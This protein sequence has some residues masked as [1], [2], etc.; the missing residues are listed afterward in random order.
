MK[1]KGLKDVCV[2]DKP[3]NVLDEIREK[4]VTNI[5]GAPFYICDLTDIIK[6]HRTWTQLLP[7]VLPFYGKVQ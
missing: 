2:M 5:Q 3:L 7:R 1:V 6:K 4:S